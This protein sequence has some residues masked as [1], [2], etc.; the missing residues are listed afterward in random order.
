MNDSNI[1]AKA[2]NAAVQA[3][4]I[5]KN[6]VELAA[7]IVAQ[8]YIGAGINVVQL[9]PYVIAVV[10]F[11]IIVPFVIFISLPAMVL[12]N[13]NETLD[14]YTDYA[15]PETFLRDSVGAIYSDYFNEYSFDKNSRLDEIKDDFLLGI[16]DPTVNYSEFG[17]NVVFDISRETS[18]SGEPVDVLWYAAIHSVYFGNDPAKTTRDSMSMIPGGG[19]TYSVTEIIT[20]IIEAT[21]NTPLILSITRTLNIEYNTP[22]TVMRTAEFDEQQVLWANYMHSVI[23]GGKG[24]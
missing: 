16:L 20:D 19:F 17:E 3:V 9:L 5:V 22:H 13:Y 15:I 14:N 1:G 8:N 11:V 23:S 24:F 6:S 21:Q 12:E 2:A 18:T 4:N 10:L 7:N